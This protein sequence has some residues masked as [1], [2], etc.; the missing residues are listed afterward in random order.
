[1]SN[2]YACDTC[3]RYGGQM[4]GSGLHRCRVTMIPRMARKPKPVDGIAYL[5]ITRP[6]VSDSQTPRDACAGWEPD[7]RH[8]AADGQGAVV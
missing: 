7:F 4:R 2:Y 5:A 8:M 3:G 1:M 6:V